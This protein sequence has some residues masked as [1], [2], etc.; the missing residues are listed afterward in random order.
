MDDG[1]DEA[2]VHVLRNTVIVLGAVV[3]AIVAGLILLWV[4]FVLKQRKYRPRDSTSIAGSTTTTLTMYQPTVNNILIQFP[5]ANIPQPHR[6]RDSEGPAV[7]V[8]VTETSF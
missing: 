4:G 7:S 2:E 6:G 8:G 3:A 5:V 1:V